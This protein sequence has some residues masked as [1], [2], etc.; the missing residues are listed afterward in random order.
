VAA[1][2]VETEEQLS[3][4]VSLGFDLYQ[5]YYFA[6]PMSAGDANELAASQSQ[7][8]SRNQAIPH[9]RMPTGENRPTRPVDSAQL[10]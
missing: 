4:V 8:S 5:G 6:L 9:P 1:E 2:G 10:D 3:E 7:A